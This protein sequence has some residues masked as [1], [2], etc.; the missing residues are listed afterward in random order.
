MQKPVTHNSVEPAAAWRPVL[1]AYEP[2]LARASVECARFVAEI[3]ANP[4]GRADVA[5][6]PFAAWQAVPAGG[7]R[8]LTLGGDAGVGKTLLARQVFV[9]ARAHWPW[10]SGIYERR[11]SDERDRRPEAVWLTEAQL[12]RRVMESREWDL[13]EYLGRDWLLVVDDLGSEPDT[14]G[15]LAGVLYRLLNERLGKWTVFTTNLSLDDIAARID[16]RVASRLVRDSN[17]YVRITAGDYA[18]RRAG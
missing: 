12:K 9:A 15:F 2:S 4:T 13:P 17:Q 8:W 10:A 7:A 14:S 5:A 1:D 6:N 18:L 11:R 3:A 16:P